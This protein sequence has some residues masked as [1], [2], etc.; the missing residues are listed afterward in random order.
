MPNPKQM[1][2]LSPTPVLDEMVKDSV[3]IMIA[4]EVPNSSAFTQLP[5]L[6]G[7]DNFLLQ[8]NADLK[9]KGTLFYDS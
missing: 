4:N 8:D 9:V 1:T 5:K 2:I 7:C 6:E 3:S